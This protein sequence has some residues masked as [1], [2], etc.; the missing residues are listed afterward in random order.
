MSIGKFPLPDL[1]I[2]Y[3]SLKELSLKEN[4]GVAISDTVLNKILSV[5][6]YN[7]IDVLS[8]NNVSLV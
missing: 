8:N 5:F 7:M 3:L 2:S 4:G 6:V 1:C